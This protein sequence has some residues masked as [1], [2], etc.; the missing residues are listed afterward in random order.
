MPISQA[1]RD[2]AARLVAKYPQP[3]SALLP[4]LYVTQ[5]DEGYVSD[6]G[7]A[8]CAETLGLTKAEVQA[9]ATFYEMFERRPVGDWVLTVCLN[10]SCKVRGAMRVYDR[11]LEQ[12]G[13]HHDDDAG[14]TVKHAECLGNCEDAPV[15]QVNYQNYPRCT[16][17]SADA[18]VTALRTGEP[19]RAANGEPPARFRE[20]SL[21][22]SGAL[23]HEPARSGG[24]AG[25]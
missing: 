10:F 4:L 7:I 1:T 25:G 13:G 22:L 16:P 21:R 12:V 20:V 19:P 15:V 8:F 3:R 9:V 17:E 11:L 18:L 23:D 2:H 6:D 14:I 24:H 5:A